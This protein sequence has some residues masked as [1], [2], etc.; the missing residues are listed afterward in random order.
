MYNEKKYQI[1]LKIP[2]KMSFK[3]SNIKINGK[4]NIVIASCNISV[5]I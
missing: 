2:Q 5:A 1:R 4:V 3:L